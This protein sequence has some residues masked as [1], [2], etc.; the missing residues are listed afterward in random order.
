MQKRRVAMDN[1]EQDRL[2]AGEISQLWAQYVNDSGSMCML[3]YFLE[4]A[5]DEEI[6]NIIEMALKISAAHISKLTDK[7]KEEKHS[8]PHGFKIGEDVDVHATRLYSDIFVLNFIHQ[9]ARIGLTTYSA[10]VAS[11]VRPDI[12]DYYMKPIS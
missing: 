1:Q 12:T 10:S 11:S 9:M 3:A 5:E 4:K 6:R 2:T 7:F 8:I